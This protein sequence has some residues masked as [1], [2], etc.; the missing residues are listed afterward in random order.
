MVSAV[1]LMIINKDPLGP[2][3]SEIKKMTREVNTPTGKQTYSYTCIKDGFLGQG[4]FGSVYQVR[5]L[6]DSA[7][8]AFKIQD[9]SKLDKKAYKRQKDLCKREIKALGS[10]NNPNVIHLEGSYFDKK[11]KK[12]LLILELATGGELFDDVSDNFNSKYGPL[13]QEFVLTQFLQIVRGVNAIHAAGWIHRDLK[14]EN[15]VISGNALK[16]IDLGLS[17]PRDESNE[18]RMGTPHTVDPLAMA[19]RGKFKWTPSADVYGLG[20]ILYLMLHARYPFDNAND[21]YGRQLQPFDV[22][23]KK[24]E[25]VID[26]FI[27]AEAACLIS[28]MLT[29]NINNRISM[30]NLITRL[31]D[32]VDE[33]AQKRQQ[34]D[35]E[36]LNNPLSNKVYDYSIMPIEK[37][38]VNNKNILE[39]DEEKGSVSTAEDELI[40]FRSRSLTTVQKPLRRMPPGTTSLGTA[41]NPLHSDV[42]S[43]ETKI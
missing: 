25:Y 23:Y 24:N 20:V 27:E 14:M 9:L 31:T 6:L 42:K 7:V 40:N 13:H 39:I 28:E 26:K 29:I 19:T 41:E 4:A 15:V 33:L 10:V 3:E 37:I 2:C 12:F 32:L 18:E 21:I 16:V 36:K 35:L 34:N 30:S 17:V 1:S 22:A 8:F 38:T 43:S 11:Q 5:R